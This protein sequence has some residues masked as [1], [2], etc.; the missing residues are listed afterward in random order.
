MQKAKTIIVFYF[1]IL[2]I[3]NIQVIF[4]FSSNQYFEPVCYG[5]L[6]VFS[7]ILFFLTKGKFETK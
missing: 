5:F 2:C 6:I 4:N 1:I 7:I 3:L